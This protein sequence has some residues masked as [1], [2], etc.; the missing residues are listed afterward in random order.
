MKYECNTKEEHE[1]FWRLNDLV[2]EMGSSD[3]I[4]YLAILMLEYVVTKV[5][6]NKDEESKASV[7]EE[8]RNNMEFYFD[9]IL[10]YKPDEKKEKI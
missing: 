4:I 6:D 8:I 1:R 9:C 7:L 2:K 10:T 5:S 3:E